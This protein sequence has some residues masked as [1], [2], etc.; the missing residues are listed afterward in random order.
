MYTPLISMLCKTV[1]DCNFMAS[2]FAFN[3]ADANV[4]FVVF[5]GCQYGL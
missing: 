3:F 1:H 2:S 4:C 5:D